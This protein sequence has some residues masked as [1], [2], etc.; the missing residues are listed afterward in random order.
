[1]NSNH[2]VPRLVL[3]STLILL[4]LSILDQV[5]GF[6]YPAFSRINLISDIFS[7]PSHSDSITPAPGQI[8]VKSG[9]PDFTLYRKPNFI[10]NFNSDTGICAMPH[11]AARLQE[12]KSGKNRKVRIAFFG[13]S[14][15]E[16]DLLTQTLRKLLQQSFGGQ[17]VGFVPIT[18]PVSQ[19]R[20]TVNTDDY[21]EWKDENFKTAKHGHLFF[22][23]H[24]FRT[25]GA[26][27]RM[28]DRTISVKDVPLEKSLL[29]GP[30]PNN[31]RI[32]VNDVPRTIFP[33]QAFNRVLLGNEPSPYI[34][35]QV[36]SS[37]LPVYGISFESASGIMVDNFSFRGITGIE[38]NSLDTSFLHAI[39]KNNAYDL[40]IL[41]YGV[42]MLFR[43]NEKE[44]SWYGKNMLPVVK[45][46][47]EA[48]AKSELVLVSTA[49]RA[50]RYGTD[51]R[52]ATGIDSLIQTQARIAMTTSSCFYNQF[53]TMGGPN[54][55]VDWAAR[56]PSLANRDYIHPNH[57]GAELLGRYFYEAI[58]K[59]FD[60]YIHSLRK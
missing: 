6:R 59:D 38:L 52:S 14:M 53:A 29:C 20:S 9:Q 56:S 15:I 51:Y 4:L 23:G 60:K 33:K 26:W 7:S 45:K 10:T 13:D 58:M 5:F 3:A 55:I 8:P 36:T 43:P 21:G 12:L 30:A 34:K 57:R 27:V 39:A 1:M 17:G 31:V 44:F 47:R 32:L 24:L 19:F 25:E 16:G 46:L 54:S 28:T 40:I 42:N 48:F 18:S 22:S 37:R 50:F 41:Q 2:R 49:D 35:L 11:F